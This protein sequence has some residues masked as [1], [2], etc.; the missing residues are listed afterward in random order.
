MEPA[1]TK[2]C[3]RYLRCEKVC[4]DNPQKLGAEF[5]CKVNIANGGVIPRVGLNSA[6]GEDSEGI[7][8]FLSNANRNLFRLGGKGASTC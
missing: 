7:G 1:R 4:L 3:K 2:G 6:Q 8:S 5:H